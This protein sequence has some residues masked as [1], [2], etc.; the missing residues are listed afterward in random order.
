MK[1]KM[2]ILGLLCAVGLAACNRGEVTDVQR[3][4]SGGLDNTTQLSA[5]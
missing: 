1:S 4:P 2:L 3:D 5:I